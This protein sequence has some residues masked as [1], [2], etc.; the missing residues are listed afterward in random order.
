MA[1]YKV[2]KYVLIKKESEFPLTISGKVKKF[3]IQKISKE[4]LG[5][6][7]VKSHFTEAVDN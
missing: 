5:L 7:T 3:E 2:P 6:G 1:H 4:L